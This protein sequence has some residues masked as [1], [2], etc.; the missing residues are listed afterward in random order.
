MKRC[1]SVRRLQCGSV[2]DRS[3]VGNNVFCGTVILFERAW[4]DLATKWTFEQILLNTADQVFSSLGGF[5]CQDW[6]HLKMVAGNDQSCIF[7]QGGKRRDRRG[8]LNLRAFI[9]DRHIE[10]RPNVATAGP[11]RELVG[12]HGRCGDNRDGVSSRQADEAVLS[13]LVT[14]MQIE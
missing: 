7:F 4:I 8:Y 9:N 5:E 2:T 12:L 1:R 10:N 3:S 13:L 11:L 14:L 6:R